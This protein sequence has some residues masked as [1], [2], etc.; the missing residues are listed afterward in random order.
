M[1]KKT[2]FLHPFIF[3]V[4]HRDEKINNFSTRKKNKVEK[5]ISFFIGH[6][7]L[8]YVTTFSASA[9]EQRRRIGVMPKPT[10][11][12]LQVSQPSTAQDKRV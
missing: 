10:T 3:R 7:V 6:E 1:I 2:P 12:R 8:F 4:D 5:R 11:G 9:V